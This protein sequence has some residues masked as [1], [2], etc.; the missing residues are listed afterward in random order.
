MFNL[1]DSLRGGGTILL[2]FFVVL[3]VLRSYAV[4]SYALDFVAT[5]PIIPI[6]DQRSVA[7]FLTVIFQGLLIYFLFCC[8][9]SFKRFKRGSLNPWFPIF[10][11]AMAFPLLIGAILLVL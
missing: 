3:V 6:S 8:Q 4:Y 2:G 10:Y 1:N 5:R 7:T 9:W 11:A